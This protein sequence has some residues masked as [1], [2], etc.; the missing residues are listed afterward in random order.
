M[1]QE[2]VDDRQVVGYE[3][4]LPWLPEVF[5][6]RGTQLERFCLRLA[7]Y[8]VGWTTRRGAGE[9]LWHVN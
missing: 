4:E 6:P 8:L 9:A 7:Q 2:R 3:W 5:G 1:S